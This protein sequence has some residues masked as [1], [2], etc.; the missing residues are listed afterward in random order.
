[1]ITPAPFYAYVHVTDDGE[2]FYVGKGSGRRAFQRWGR[3]AEHTAR[4][5]KT[6]NVGILP[7][8]TERIAYELEW[9]LIKCLHRSGVQLANKQIPLGEAERRRTDALRAKLGWIGEHK[10]FWDEED[11]RI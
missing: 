8:S 2:I 6:L 3:N 7:C 1:M 11:G 4:M 10:P 9:G 5:G